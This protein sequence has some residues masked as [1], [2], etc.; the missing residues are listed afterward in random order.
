MRNP[1]TLRSGRSR[2]KEIETISIRHPRFVIVVSEFRS[3]RF[4]KIDADREFRKRGNLRYREENRVDR[5]G[6]ERTFRVFL[7]LHS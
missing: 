2:A 3:T 4:P 5:V 1:L 6:L 7:L